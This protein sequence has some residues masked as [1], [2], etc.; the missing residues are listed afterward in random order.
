MKWWKRQCV[1]INFGRSN[2]LGWVAVIDNDDWQR[3]AGYWLNG[4]IFGRYV[5]LFVPWKGRF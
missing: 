4:R 5:S 3:R 1:L 2:H